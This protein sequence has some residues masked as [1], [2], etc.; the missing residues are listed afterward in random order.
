MQRPIEANLTG[1]VAVVTGANTGIGKEIARDLARLRAT[2][3]LA[4]RDEERGNAALDE[5]VADTGNHKT[6][7]LLVDTSSQK[8]I[9]SFAATL[10]RKHPAIH[11]LVNNAGIWRDDRGVSDDGI[12]LTWATNM[13][14]YFVMTNE[15]LPLLIKGTSA[16]SGVTLGGTSAPLNSRIVNVVS[17]MARDL[18]LGDV[19]MDRRGYDGITAYAQS[20]QAN[21][22]WSWALAARLARTPITVNAVHPGWVASELASRCK[23]LKGAV[24]CC[25]FRWFARTPAVGADTPSWLA[26][27]PAIEGVRGKYWI[28]RS[29]RDCRFK[30]DQ[31]SN[32][33]L[34]ALCES[35]TSSAGG[36]DERSAPNPP[37]GTRRDET[38]VA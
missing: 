19:E 3:V 38:R 28:D 37:P 21:R 14:G 1:R 9:R 24:A 7:L 10:S 8:S 23:G 31:A 18:D 13:L 30:L 17:E 15:L 12:E 11:V 25:A 36:S 26:A 34:W 29:E 6:E 20:K 16:S 22:M 35:M 27:S 33:R 2:V 5:I 4:C 32:E